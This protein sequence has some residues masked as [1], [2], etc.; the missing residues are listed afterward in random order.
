MSLAFEWVARI[1]AVSLLM[2][3]PGVAGQW[4]DNRFST[5]FLALVGF[6]F[7][8][9]AGLGVLLVMV[10]PAKKKNPKDA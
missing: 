6:A 10:R 9:C 3:M 7:G 8:F 4:L 5:N 1:F 2:F